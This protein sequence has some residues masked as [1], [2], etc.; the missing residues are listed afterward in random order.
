MRV[1]DHA[2]DEAAGESAEPVRPALVRERVVTVLAPQ[3]EV[4]VETGAALV[5]ERPAH[6]R[7]EQALAG[8]ELLDRGLEHE[9]P[10][11]RVERRP[12]A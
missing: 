12:S 2:G 1:L 6:E 5:G 4:E 8:G 11:A 3:R 10:V 9:G 7:R